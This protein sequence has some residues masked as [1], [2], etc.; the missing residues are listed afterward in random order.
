MEKISYGYVNTVNKQDGT[1]TVL[2]PDKNQNITGSIPF[3]SHCGE[4]KLPDIGEPVAVIYWGAGSADG[5][6]LG[7]WWSADNPPPNGYD[8]YKDTGSG[9]SISQQGGI[10]TFQDSGGKISVEEIIKKLEDH[11]RRITKLGG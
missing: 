8:F 2:Q 3:F 1:I 6:A 4:Y 10:L 5:V 11:E 7:G 9:S